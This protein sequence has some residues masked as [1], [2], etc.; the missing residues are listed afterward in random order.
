STS[1]VGTNRGRLPAIALP[2]AWGAN[3]SVALPGWFIPNNWHNVIYYS[4]ARQNTAGGGA[5]CTTCSASATLSLD[6]AAGVSALFFTPGTPPA[7]INR[8]STNVAD[9]LLDAQNNDNSDDVYVTPAPTP[10]DRNR[11]TTVTSVATTAQCAT[12]AAILIANADCNPTGGGWANV[13]PACQAAATALQA[14][15]CAAAATVMVTPPCGNN[16][17]P[18]QCQAAVGILQACNI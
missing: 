6:G 11:I 18:P 9:Y 2:E 15:S 7:G 13:K 17:N 10:T 16:G 5:A 3:A 12:N 4:V 8:P 14:C 1:L